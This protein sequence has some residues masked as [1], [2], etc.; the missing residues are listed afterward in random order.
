MRGIACAL[1]LA[2][3]VAAL[4]GCSVNE[5][6]PPQPST[7]VPTPATVVIGTLP[8][9]D[10]LPLWVAIENGFAVQNGVDIVI[11]TFASAQEQIAAVSAGELD[12]IMTD[13]VVTVQ[14]SASGTRMRVVTVLQGSPA[15]IVANADSGIETVADLAGVPVGCSSPTIMQYILDTALTKADVPQQQWNTT[16]IKDLPTRLEV[17]LSRQIGVAVLPWTMH[18]Y[19]VQQG[20]VSLI[21]PGQ[22]D[23]V[24]S[25]VLAFRADFLNQPG[26]DDVVAA[27]WR[28]WD[29]G[30]ASV[31]ASPSTYEDLLR[32]K[33]SLPDDLVYP[34]RTYPSS[35]P[36]T[37][38]QVEAV[39]AWMMDRGYITTPVPFDDLKYPG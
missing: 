9:D 14:L 28:S 4:T 1:A 38:G 11:Q 16:E 36:V 33:A 25:T 34:V 20:A 23:E 39:V 15:G 17:L 5:S 35:A 37:Q 6:A 10:L 27:I 31:N 30:V 3:S 7:P 18:A 26:A 12:A 22:A 21:G 8:T 19:A 13:L 32:T 24:T 2:M 29:A